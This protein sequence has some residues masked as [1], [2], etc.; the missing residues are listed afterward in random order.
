MQTDFIEGECDVRTN[1]D[2]DGDFICHGCKLSH[3]FFEFIGSASPHLVVEHLVEH[4]RAGHHVPQKLIEYWQNYE[5]GDMVVNFGIHHHRIVNDKRHPLL[6]RE[7]AVEWEKIC[8]PQRGINYGH[9]T[10]QDLMFVNRTGVIACSM[11]QGMRRDS[12]TCWTKITPRDAAIV[13]TVIQWLGTNCGFS[14]LSDVLD[15]AGY[16]LVRKDAVKS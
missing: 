4:M 12:V 3:R 15:R 8:R 2:H 16:K 13:A 6:E 9:G 1:I 11:T 10:L 7:F 14:F 5:V